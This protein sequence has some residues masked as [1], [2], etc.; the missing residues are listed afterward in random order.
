MKTG[1][2]TVLFLLGIFGTAGNIELNH[3]PVITIVMFTI[4]LILITSELKKQKHE[5]NIH[6]YTSHSAERLNFKNLSKK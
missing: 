1:I 6:D 3:N 5:E 2:G 4:G